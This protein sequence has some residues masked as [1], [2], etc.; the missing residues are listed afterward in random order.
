MVEEHA[1]ALQLDRVAAGDDVDQ[2]PA[3]GEAVEGRRHA[4]G[5]RRRLCRPGRIATR[6]CSRSV[7]G[8]QA[9]ATTQASSQER[10]VGSSTP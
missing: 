6:N 3:V 2:Q 8:D 10:P 9:E 5:Q 1:V 4:R 7:S